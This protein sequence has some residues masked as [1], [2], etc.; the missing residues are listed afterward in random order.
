MVLAVKGRLSFTNLPG[1]TLSCSTGCR[2]EVNQPG[3]QLYTL[4]GGNGFF[5]NLIIV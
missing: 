2:Y 1:T 5:I 4:A 3:N